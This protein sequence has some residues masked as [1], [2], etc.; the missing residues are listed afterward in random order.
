MLT[1]RPYQTEGVAGLRASFAAGKRAPLY[2]LPTGGGKTAISGSVAAGAAAR[3]RIAWFVVPSLVL[4]A[5]TAEKFAEYGI[6]AGIIHAGFSPDATAPVQVITI[7]T[8][9]RW[10]RK[11][12]VR[13]PRTGRLFF[14]AGKR[15]PAMWAPDLIV[16][17]EAHHASAAQYLRVVAA[18]PDSR[19]LGVTATPLRLDGKGLGAHVGGCFDDLVEGPS[20]TDLIGL[21]HLVHPTVYAPSVGVD[22]SGVATRAG[23]YAVAEAAA[24]V[25]KPAITGSVVG[26][27]KG[28]AAGARAV[29]FC[30]SI[31]HS[32]HVA[33]EFRAAGVVAQHLDGE[34]P[35]D[36]RRRIIA[37]FSRGEIRVMTNCALVSEGFDVPAVEAA[38]LLRPTQSLAMFLQQVGRALRPAAGKGRAVILDHVGNVQRHGLPDEDRTWSLEGGRRKSGGD[39]DTKPPPVRQC[40][41]CFA[42][43]RPAPKCPVCGFTYV[44]QAREVEHREGELKAVDRA[45]LDRMRFEQRREVRDAS[46]RADLERIAAA[47]GYKPGWVDHQLSAR[48][49]RAGARSRAM[50]ADLEH[51]A[52]LHGYGGAR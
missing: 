44:A 6:R 28:L 8:L 38:I 47:R 12:V 15:R 39:A 32:Q 26:H 43:H 30:C 40:P 36:E 51:Q 21:G 7:Q 37:A 5:Q 31:A 17:D 52:R 46:T 35:E 11:G 42:A 49:Q 24:R 18:L 20:I 10:C 9:D 33:D 29:A 2:V 27:Y 3:G 41:E 19:L 23:D 34:T 45:A 13:D 16:L 48:G 22:L 4:L 14:P 1:L 50:D 25:D